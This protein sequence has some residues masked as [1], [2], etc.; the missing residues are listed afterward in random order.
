MTLNKHTVKMPTESMQ[1]I[2]TNLRLLGWPNELPMKSVMVN[3]PCTIW[4]RQS[5]DNFLW[6]WE[7]CKGLCREYSSRYFKRTH[8]VQ[9]YMDTL[10]N[11]NILSFLDN[12]QFPEGGLTPF[13]LA[14]PDECK[15]DSP[16]ESYRNYYRMEK[17]HIAEW[18]EP[19]IMPH[20]WKH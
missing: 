3:H 8:K 12:V 13:V 14:M 17:S 16:V 9:E 10:L 6:L 18:K 1:M 20:W 2:C 15:V 4:A 19:A 5:K 7:H 11:K